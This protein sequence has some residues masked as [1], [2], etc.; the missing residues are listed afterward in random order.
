MSACF[1]NGQLVFMKKDMVMIML[2]QY[3]KLKQGLVSFCLATALLSCN[4][5]VHAATTEEEIA[6][7]QSIPIESNEIDNWPEGPVVSAQ[8]AILMEVST[9]TILYE[10]NIHEQLYPASITKILTC[11]VAVDHMESLDEMVDVS[12]EAVYTVPYDGTN[13]GLDAGQS[14][15]LEDCLYGILMKSANEAC[16]AVGEHFAGSISGYVDMMNEKAKELGCADSHFVTTNGLHDEE[17]YTSAY[18]MALIARE[19]FSNELLSKI[20][21]TIYHQIPATDTQPDLIDM[22]AKNSLLHNREYAYEYI[23]GSKTGYTSQSKQ[24]LVSC[25][26]KDGMKLVCVVLKEDSPSQFTDTI[27]L[28]DYGFNQFSLMNASEND[29]K[30]VIDTSD[31]F[32]SD[33]DV[34]GSS[35]QFISLDSDAQ[36]VVPNTLSFSDLSSTLTYH[37]D[38]EGVIASIDYSYEGKAMGSCHVLLDE[39]SQAQELV[40]DTLPLPNETDEKQEEVAG[41]STVVINLKPI[42]IA[43]LCILVLVVLI[44][45]LKK[46]SKSYHFGKTIQEKFRKFRRNQK[47]RQAKRRDRTN[48]NRRNHYKRNSSQISMTQSLQIG[49]D[50]GSR[51]RRPKPTKLEHFETKRN[52]SRSTRKRLKSKR[53]NRRKRKQM[54]VRIHFNHEDLF[55]D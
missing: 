50:S 21:G 28:F 2:K 10:K 45:I 18:D 12:Y 43:V 3:R 31:F 46:V 1:L 55:D 33:L 7:R 54:E 23:V 38:Q 44:L 15:T 6:A 40:F 5:P 41:V 52:V 27:T 9:G 30:Y 39:G 51:R 8:S 42:F 13:I 25:A 32:Q 53:N 22:Y 49:I 14:L 16:N 4:M 19:F 11:L 20:S 35:K 48:A 17:H 29:T 36:I 26:Q 37:S 24:T 47:Q 34:F